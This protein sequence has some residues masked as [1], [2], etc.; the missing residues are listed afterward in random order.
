MRVTTDDG[1]GLDVDVTGEGP[2]LVLVHGFTGAKEDFADQ[3]PA[4]ARL[5]RVIMFDLRGHGASDKP[6]DG[7]A[8]TLDR[9]ALDVLA[10]ADALGA[11]R[12]RLLGHSMGGMVARRVV[13]SVP[14]RVT[15]LILM[16]T[17][18]GPPSG[19][20]PD[21]AK[22]AAVLAVTDGMEVLRELLDEMNPLNTAA[23]ER[24]ARERPGYEE[25]DR[26]K[27]MKTSPVAYA[28][29][30]TDI[31]DQPDALADLA[32]VRCPTLVIVGEQDEAFLPDSRAMAE[33]I[34][35]ADLV[36]VP[37]AGHSPQFENPDV[38]LASMERLLARVDAEQVQAQ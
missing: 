2:A 21:L 25:W 12:F 9:L 31:V 37:D 29:L 35:G 27:F 36:V 33:V 11:D 28:N 30:I 4:L 38:Y 13:L 10:V 32:H 20:D 22:A 17:S 18:P 23:H 6:D 8:Y 34:P 7:A 26:S 19:V 3:V 5:S 14:E 15:G 16:D 1:V 24:V